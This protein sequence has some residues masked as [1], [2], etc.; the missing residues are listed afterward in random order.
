MVCF[1]FGFCIGFILF[2]VL[3]DNAYAAFLSLLECKE[4]PFD[5]V[6]GQ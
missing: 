6:E 2:I 1:I 3:W 5:G 4:R